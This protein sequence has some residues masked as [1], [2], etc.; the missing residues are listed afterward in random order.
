MHQKQKST[1]YT[2]TNLA[3][4]LIARRTEG[5][6]SFEGLNCLA[7]LSH[8]I[9][10]YFLQFE[11]SFVQKPQLHNK[12][13]STNNTE[14]VIKVF[15]N[16]CF[17]FFFFTLIQILKCLVSRTRLTHKIQTSSLCWKKIPSAS[18]VLSLLISQSVLTNSFISIISY[19][20][21]K[22]LILGCRFGVKYSWSST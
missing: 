20:L 17:C 15:T 7:F 10:I 11:S 12:F 9:I 6:C 2:L 19:R 1:S 13:W 8:E 16:L 18:E 14:D 22:C 21:L 4:S 3:S 5:V